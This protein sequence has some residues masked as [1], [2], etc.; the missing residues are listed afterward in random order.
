[1]TLSREAIQYSLFAGGIKCEYG[2]ATIPVI[3]GVAAA[4]LGRS[5][6]ITGRI[7]DYAGEWTCAVRAAG[8][9]IQNR[10]VTALVDL[11]HHSI[12]SRAAAACRAI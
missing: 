6:K 8:K 3:A 12:E 4:I 5:V 7:S 9:I 10:F 2:T 1:V 11:E